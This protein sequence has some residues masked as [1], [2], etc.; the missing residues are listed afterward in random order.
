MDHEA[1][2]SDI[3][4]SDLSVRNTAKAQIS[5]NPVVA[6]TIGKMERVKLES[7]DIEDY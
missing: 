6:A 4:C 7:T 5:L 1:V 2:K 3:Q